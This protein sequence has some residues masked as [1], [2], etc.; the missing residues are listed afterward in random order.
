MLVSG[1]WSLVSGLWSLV[2]GLWSLVS[3]LRLQSILCFFVYVIICVCIFLCVA[4]WFWRLDDGVD[5]RV[6]VPGYRPSQFCGEE[7]CNKQLL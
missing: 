2:S 4:R 3:G 7:I 5:R 1:L 6:T